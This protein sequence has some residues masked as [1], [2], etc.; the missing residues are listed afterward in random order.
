MHNTY[1]SITVYMDSL[2]LNRK[3]EHTLDLGKNIKLVVFKFNIRRSLSQKSFLMVLALGDGLHNMK[4]S[5][6]H[7]VSIRINFLVY[8]GLQCLF[9]RSQGTALDCLP[10]SSFVH[11]SRAHIV[12]ENAPVF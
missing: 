2:Y 11:G 10:L 12:H 3:G 5:P 9:V 1:T 7:I 4:K 8:Q 6:Q